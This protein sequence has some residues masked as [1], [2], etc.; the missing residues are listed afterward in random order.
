M[1]Y[2]D[3]V[4]VN[5]DILSP[6][7]DTILNSSI[8]FLLNT[9]IMLVITF[10]VIMATLEIIAGGEGF[11]RVHVE[12]LFVFSVFNILIDVLFSGGGVFCRITY[13]GNTN[14]MEATEEPQEDSPN[15]S[16][17][18]SD[19]VAT[20]STSL[21]RNS[22]PSDT[23]RGQ[24]TTKNKKSSSSLRWCGFSWKCCAAPITNSLLRSFT[25][26]GVAVVIT[27]TGFNSVFVDALGS[28]VVFATL[29]QYNTTYFRKISEDNRNNILLE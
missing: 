16:S 23:E 6:Q 22:S 18:E 17:T 5:G 13:D 26:L 1:M 8:P 14:E 3:H 9:L 11:R 28:I 12:Y 10:I 27:V 4:K 24:N 2:I 7:M 19:M 15:S 20:D 21:L 29:I 25:V